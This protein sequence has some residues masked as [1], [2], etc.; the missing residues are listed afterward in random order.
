MRVI[1][2]LA[3]IDFHIGRITRDGNGLVVESRVGSGI[4]TAVHV[5]RDDVIAGV[6]ALLRSPG[7]FGFL[8][9]APFRRSRPAAPRAGGASSNEASDINNPWR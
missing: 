1:S 7:A 3:D 4:P 8:L 2:G 6:R 5:G 9:S